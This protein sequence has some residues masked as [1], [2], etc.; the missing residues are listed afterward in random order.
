MRVLAMYFFQFPFHCG[1]IFATS[2]LADLE[3]LVILRDFVS[4]ILSTMVI[5]S[6]AS[7]RFNVIMIANEMT[8]KE[9]RFLR[10]TFQTVL[11]L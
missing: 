5:V 11:P 1:G 2:S 7:A 4:V 8:V 10:F 9:K 6:A 3:I